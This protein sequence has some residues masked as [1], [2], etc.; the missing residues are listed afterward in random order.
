MQWNRSHVVIGGRGLRVAGCVAVVRELDHKEHHDTEWG[1]RECTGVRPGG[2]LAMM[3]DGAT[4]ARAPNH[5]PTGP[6]T[7]HGPRPHPSLGLLVKRVNEQNAIAAI[8]DLTGKV[9]PLGLWSGG[10]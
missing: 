6:A 4:A 1:S 7:P 9:R 5:H 2:L 8:N 10:V 3:A